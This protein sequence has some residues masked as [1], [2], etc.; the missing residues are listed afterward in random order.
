M[1]YVRY[2]DDFL[3]GI[4]GNKVDCM[5]LKEKI[6]AYLHNELKLDLNLDKTAITH[7]RKSKAHFLGADISITPLDKRPLRLV[8]RG[9]TSFRMRTVTRPLLMAPITKLVL[10]L[11]EKGFAK[12]GGRPTYLARMLH[13][14]TNQIVKHFWQI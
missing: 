2:A 8:N 9:N 6:H 14:E 7:A 11:T 5:K 10:K 12:N 4:I 3:I 13:F 1:K